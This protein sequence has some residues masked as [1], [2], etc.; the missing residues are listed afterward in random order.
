M[1]ALAYLGKAYRLDTGRTPTLVSED[2]QHDPAKGSFDAYLS[3]FCS[4]AVVP[5]GAMRELFKHHR[6]Q[7]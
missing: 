4:L 2:W 1:L 3:T 6:P 5:E 7:A